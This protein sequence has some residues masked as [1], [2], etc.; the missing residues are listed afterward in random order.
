MAERHASAAA[1]GKD[2]EYDSVLVAFEDDPFHEETVAT[3]ARL[4]AHRRRGIH[5]L[6][7][8]NV[9]FHLALDEPLAA[10]ESAAQSKIEQAKLIA[11]QRVTG[12]V[13]RVRSGQAGRAIADEAESIRAEA[14]VVQLTYRRRTPLYGKTLQTVLRRRPCRVI[15]VA[16]PQLAAPAP[17]EG[18]ATSA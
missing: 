6:S 9:P 13:T 7:L 17:R 1:L 8:L 10:Q 12:H 16:Q 18:L 2:V 4:A 3:A 15:V 11:G 14:I 5:V